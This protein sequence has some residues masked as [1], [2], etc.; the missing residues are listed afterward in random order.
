[1]SISG[2]LSNA[3]TGLTAATRAAEVVS[4]NL[5]NSLTEGYGRREI[6]LSS[7]ITGSTGGV[8]VDGVK[9][10]VNP[11][12]V[13]DRRFA[14]ADYSNASTNSAYLRRFE[15][16]LGTPEDSYS[17][18]AGLAKFESS[19]VEAASRPE[20]N[21]RLENVF[22]RSQNVAQTLKQSSDGVQNL[23][24]E[25]DRE[26]DSTVDR[27][28]TALEQVRELNVR[29]SAAQVQGNETASLEDM[30][31]QTID[32]IGEIVPIREVPRDHGAVALFTPGGS[33]LLDGS[34]A[35]LEFTTTNVIAPH[36]TQANGM[37][38]GLT[39]NGNPVRTD[40]ATSPIKGGSLSA[41][42]EI[43][44]ETGVE[45]QAQ[46]DAVA[47]DLVERYQ[48]PA[49]DPTLAATDPGLFTD[50]GLFFD[51]ANEVGLAGRLS[52]NAAVDPDAGGDVSR[53]RD[54]LGAAA[55][56][57]VGDATLLQSMYGALNVLRVPASGSFGGASRSAADLTAS[58]LSQAGSDRQV[59]ET[60]LAFSTA[61][62]DELKT[63]ELS[64]G[65]DSDYEIQRLMLIEQAYAANARMIETVDEMMQ[66]LL[67]L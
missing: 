61:R 55:P 17:L 49:V 40:S 58:L 41:L 52:I 36:M 29:I 43:R 27:L 60:H 47:R 54:G 35:T 66:T 2:A 28:N 42:F 34:A 39:I 57:P 45:S 56:G 21:E 44:D 63:M 32:E 7:R 65:V 10:M 38:S 50:G 26:I 15:G 24:I 5:A 20:S 37:L 8:A 3:L 30:R 16:L 62:L 33:I 1:M 14:D 11:A 6:S 31:Q 59:G 25:A 23:R 19:L 67:R 46:L 12:L 51:P 64:E 22:L 13:S 18:S 53:L 48:D 4:S 9:R